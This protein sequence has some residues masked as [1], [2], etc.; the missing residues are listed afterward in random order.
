MTNGRTEK[1][2]AMMLAQLPPDGTNIGNGALIDAMRSAGLGSGLE[3]TDDEFHEARDRLIAAGLAKKGR[4]RGGSTAQVLGAQEGR[5]AAWAGPAA[6]TAIQS[7]ENDRPDFALQAE[8]LPAELPFNPPKIARKSAARPQAG[9]APGDPQVLA[10]RHA[11]R[12]ANNPEVGLVSEASD[13]ERPKT[14]WAYDPH[15]DPVL[16]FDSA[17]AKAE[18]LIEDALA[19]DDPAAMRAALEALRRLGSPY[20]QW[21]GK[22]ERTSFAVDTVSLH[23]HERIDPM[24]ILSAVSKA[25]DARP[26]K[27]ARRAVAASSPACLMRRSRACRCATRWIF[28]ATTRAGATG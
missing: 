2:V 9:A 13:P 5:P 21:A 11:D 25:R 10:Y 22:A 7:P 6:A 23:V 27:V 3:P 26:S 14:V 4:G 18:K 15:L 24:S 17:R 1:I 28:T 8:M 16:N 12:R 19:G 20:L